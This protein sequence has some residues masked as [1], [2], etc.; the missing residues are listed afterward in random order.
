VGVALE[1]QFPSLSPSRHPGWTICRCFS[2]QRELD[3]NLLRLKGPLASLASIRFLAA[4]EIEGSQRVGVRFTR[5]GWQAL[6][7]MGH[8]PSIQRRVSSPQPLGSTSPCSTNS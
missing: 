5:R 2:L 7:Y 6:L 8:S 4:I 1:Q 3:I